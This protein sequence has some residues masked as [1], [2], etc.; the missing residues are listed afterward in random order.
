[1]ST[2]DGSGRGAAIAAAVT[3]RIK[4]DKEGPVVDSE[5]QNEQ[6][7]ESAQA[8]KPLQA[9]GESAAADKPKAET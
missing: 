5:S 9:S 8:D 4:R 6:S 1:M 2:A 3:E 7:D